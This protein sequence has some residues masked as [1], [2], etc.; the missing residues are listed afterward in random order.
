V[1]L[2]AESMMEVVKP[3]EVPAD[4][5]PWVKPGNAV[6]LGPAEFPIEIWTDVHQMKL[7]GLYGTNGS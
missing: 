6:V 5:M 7:I 4:L 2:K 1:S 3:I